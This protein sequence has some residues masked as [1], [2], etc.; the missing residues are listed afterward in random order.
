[1]VPKFD[2]FVTASKPFSFERHEGSIQADFPNSV[3]LLHLVQR[4]P[5]P[6]FACQVQALLNMHTFPELLYTFP[7]SPKQN[8]KT[9]G[10]VKV[11]GY[12]LLMD[13]LDVFMYTTLNPFGLLFFI[14]TILTK[15]M[16]MVG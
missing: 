16:Q 3:K 4:A 9:M 12:F 8:K 1:M 11:F 6:S 5:P 14:S 10:S 13:G 2:L 15:Q 7:N